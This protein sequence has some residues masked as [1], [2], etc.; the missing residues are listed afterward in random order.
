MK[1]HFSVELLQLN[2]S[3][4]IQKREFLEW[5]LAAL[6]EKRR[7][8]QEMIYQIEAMFKAGTASP[9]S[10]SDLNDEVAT[11]SHHI[12]RFETPP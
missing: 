8:I 12:A 6:M 10:V 7:K 2:E 9:V 5:C 3:T 11:I 1:T 4:R